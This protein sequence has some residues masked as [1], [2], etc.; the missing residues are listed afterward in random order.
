MIA[1]E[2]MLVLVT[3]KSKNHHQLDRK[4]LALDRDQLILQASRLRSERF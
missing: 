3:L 4:S 1:A 2:I